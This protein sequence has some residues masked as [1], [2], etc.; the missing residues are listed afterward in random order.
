MLHVRFEDR[1]G[2]LV[3]TPLAR[4]IDAEVAVEFRRAVVEAAQGRPLVVLSF[5][6]VRSVDA[7]GLAALVAILK[8]L[9]PAGELRLVHVQPRVAALLALT[10]LDEVFRTFPDTSAALPA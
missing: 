5:L 2:A 4:R 10:R 9:A 7:S 6:H 1:G 3:V 8:A